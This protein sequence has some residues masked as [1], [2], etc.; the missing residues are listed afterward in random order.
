MK[1][2]RSKSWDSR[3]KTDGLPPKKCSVKYNV[4]LSGGQR[5]NGTAPRIWPLAVD[6]PLP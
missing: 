1:N 2:G 5:L 4:E 3:E 6:R